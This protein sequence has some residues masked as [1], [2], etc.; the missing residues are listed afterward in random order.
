MLSA[1]AAFAATLL[2][3]TTVS[4]QTLER[5]NEYVEFSSVNITDGSF[6]VSLVPSSKYSVKIVVDALLSDYVTSSVRDKAVYI[7]YDSKSVP[8]E[9]KKLYAGRQKPDPVL[10]VVIYAPTL[11][12]LYL[13]DGSQFSSTG[14]FTAERFNVTLVD[15]AKVNSL[16]MRAENVGILLKKKASAVMNL[17]VPGC[18]TVST[19]GS[20]NVRVTGTMGAVATTSA[21]SSTILVEGKSEELDIHSE[22]SSQVTVNTETRKAR[23][24][25]AN[26]SRVVLSGSATELEVAGKNSASVDVRNVKVDEVRLGVHSATVNV[27]EK[28]SL[29]LDLAGGAAVYY[30]GTPQFTVE[31]IIK[32]TLAPAG[33]K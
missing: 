26:S 7:G 31:K 10:Q 12:E 27:G 4:A 22:G 20:S 6:D 2:L 28:K 24:E 23:I 33:T 17:E 13:A 5:V 9:V 16:N 14:D 18:L 11:Q 25:S 21:G 15:N 30:E 19:E 29:I 8:K 32:S 3:G 1:A